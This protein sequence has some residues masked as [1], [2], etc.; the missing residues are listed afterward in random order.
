ME[1]S[2]YVSISTSE[3]LDKIIKTI[4]DFQITQ[5][6]LI[7]SVNLNHDE[8]KK[9]KIFIDIQGKLDII[10]KQFDNFLNDN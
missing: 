6:K 2:D 8:K 4:N 9:D 10:F 3:K 7:N 1:V 5:N